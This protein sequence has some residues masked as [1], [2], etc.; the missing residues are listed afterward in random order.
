MLAGFVVRRLVLFW[1]AFFVREFFLRRVITIE[2]LLSFRSPQTA[3]RAA[4]REGA[5]ICWR[6]VRTPWDIVGGKLRNAE[7]YRRGNLPS[8]RRKTCKTKF[9]RAD[10]LGDAADAL[11]TEDAYADW[12][13]GP[14]E[15]A[16]QKRRR[17][18]PTIE[19]NL[20]WGSCGNIG[21]MLEVNW[22][23]VGWNLYRLR[24]RAN[25]QPEEV[26]VALEPLRG[27]HYWQEISAL[28]RPSCTPATGTEARRTNK[29]L[30][31]LREELQKSETAFN[32]ACDEFREARLVVYLTSQRYC[33]NLKHQI[34]YR[35][36]NRL[37]LKKQIAEKERLLG[38][39]ERKLKKATL[40]PKQQIEQQVTVEQQEIKQLTET[41][42]GEEKI[43]SDLKAQLAKVTKANWRASRNV[44]KT[45]LKTVR[46][47]K[48]QLEK[49]R[50]ETADAETVYQD[51]AAGFAR[52]DFLNFVVQKRSLHHPLQL[53]KALAGLPGMACRESFARCKNFEFPKE[54]HLNYF[55]FDLISKAWERRQTRDSTRA[56]ITLAREQIER[57]PK[58]DSRRQ[59][60]LERLNDLRDAV[61][62]VASTRPQPLPGQVPYLVTGQFLANISRQ[63]TPFERVLPE[64]STRK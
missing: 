44:V 28:L 12:A 23:R 16:G 14:A 20:L 7:N 32:S 30:D 56:L 64:P 40:K 63:K 46:A 4:T 18:R 51:Q 45:R 22:H 5:T 19:D 26:R 50:A 52:A 39:A 31:V 13:V 54:P 17:G 35:I 42:A 6:L 27:E 41:L 11:S 43:I 36:E 21:Y 59:F 62:Y 58:A 61:G 60:L 34:T 37:Q 57:L 2:M 53:A 1:A 25:A 55:A 10:F 48:A 8:S 15:T 38:A 24:G 3:I 47:A 29:K 33:E 9:Q 49:C